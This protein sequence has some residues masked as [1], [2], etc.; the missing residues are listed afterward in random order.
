MIKEPDPCKH[1]LKSSLFIVS[2]FKNDDHERKNS[3][4]SFQR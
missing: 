2:Q 3:N 4:C 1:F